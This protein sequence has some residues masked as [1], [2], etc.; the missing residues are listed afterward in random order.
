MSVSLGYVRHVVGGRCI[1]NRHPDGNVTR[2]K[3]SP[4]VSFFLSDRVRLD[5]NEKFSLKVKIGLHSNTL[6]G[7]QGHKATQN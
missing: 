1:V 3:I 7:A 5:L 6:L 2:F 4:F